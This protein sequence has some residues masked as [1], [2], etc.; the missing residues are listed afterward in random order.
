ML[1][2]YSEYKGMDV[3]ARANLSAYSDASSVSSYAQEVVEWA[4]A[5]GLISGVT[6]TTLA[7]QGQATR[8]QV[9]AIMTRYC[10]MK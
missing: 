6:E 5:K 10:A 7:P 8:A 4:V 9:A 3:S 1:S 2:R